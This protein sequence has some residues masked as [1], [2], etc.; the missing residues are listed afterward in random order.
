M[1]FEAALRGRLRS[2]AGVAAL[3]GDRIEWSVRPQGSPLPAVTLLMIAETVDQTLEDFQERQFAR[4]QVD[5]RAETRSEA[6]AL[7]KAVIAAVA[8]AGTFDGVNFGRATF[9]PVTDRGSNSETG[10]V[11]RDSFDLIVMHD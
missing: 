7:R 5:V 4:V 3:A 9:D 1:S 10:F 6:V 11:H 2:D 8:P